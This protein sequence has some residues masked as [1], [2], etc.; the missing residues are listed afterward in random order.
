MGYAENLAI[1]LMSVEDDYLKMDVVRI[2]LHERLIASGQALHVFWQ[3]PPADKESYWSVG[4]GLA[5]V[6][7]SNWYD[8]P[9]SFD[10]FRQPIGQRVQWTDFADGIL[11]FLPNEYTATDL[12]PFPMAAAVQGRVALWW[13]RPQ[14]VTFNRSIQ[15]KLVPLR[16]ELVPAVEAINAASSQE[17]STRFPV[18]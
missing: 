16:G 4:G 2:E 6:R 12:D 5:W 9:R 14:P 11:A 1:F 18:V 10:S 17:P 8:G 7:H 15:W 3:S 13:A